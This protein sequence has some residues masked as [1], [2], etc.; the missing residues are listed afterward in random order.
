M[1]AIED[2]F[3]ILGL[4]IFRLLTIYAAP[5][6]SPKIDWEK[7]DNLTP[8]ITTD[9]A[10]N[11]RCLEVLPLEPVSGDAIIIP[12][13]ISETRLQT[14][15]QITNAGTDSVL[16]SWKDSAPI[17]ESE[18]RPLL[19]T[20][21]ISNKMI[22]KDSLLSHGWGAGGMPFSVLYMTPHGSRLNHGSNTATGT[23]HQQD[24]GK[25]IE[26]PTVPLVQPNNRV[27]ARNGPSVQSRRQYPIIPQLFISYG[28]G[29]LGK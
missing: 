6:S 11:L 9:C 5:L 7:G 25:T 12:E 2:V 16:Q 19:P 21:R 18:S 28:W 26:N 20:K 29:T 17:L 4:N 15:R 3:L 13:D 23:S 22:K 10:T 1:R 14:R 24:V 27:A 8:V